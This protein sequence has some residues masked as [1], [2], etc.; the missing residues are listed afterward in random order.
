MKTV[1]TTIKP[2]T[3]S[4]I[5][6]ALIYRHWEAD[7]KPGESEQYYNEKM[8]SLIHHIKLNLERK[9]YGQPRGTGGTLSH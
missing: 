3:R 5:M 1:H 8:D 4:Q 6:R 2:K 7:G 9:V